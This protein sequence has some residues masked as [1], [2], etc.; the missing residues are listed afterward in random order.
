MPKLKCYIN[1]FSHS[2]LIKRYIDSEGR[3]WEKSFGLDGKERTQPV[4]YE[5]GILMAR[6]YTVG[7]R[8]K[9]T[10]GYDNQV[11]VDPRAL[12]KSYDEL[13]TKSIPKVK[14]ADITN[15]SANS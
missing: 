7:E 14:S 10:F 9:K 15:S 6:N 4:F 8:L 5:N 13:R 1:Q 11:K 12:E 3:L 2:D